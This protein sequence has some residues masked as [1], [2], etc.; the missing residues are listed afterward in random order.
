[1][2][3]PYEKGREYGIIRVTK[4]LSRLSLKGDR[5]LL[6]EILAKDL[7]RMRH[8]KNLTIKEL[9]EGIISE[10][11]YRRYLRSES[12]MTTDI[13]MRFMNRLGADMI[14]YTMDLN[15]R[16]QASYPEEYELA[17]LIK[18]NRYKEAARLYESHDFSRMYSENRY[19]FLP[20]LILYMKLNLKW[21]TK[22]EYM[23]QANEI[24]DYPNILQYKV[25]TRVD[26]EALLVHLF[27]VEEEDLERISNFLVDVIDNPD[28]RVISFEPDITR[29]DVLNVVPFA[30]LRKDHI[31][32]KD[33]QII[34]RMLEEF[35]TR[36]H[37][38]LEGFRIG[39]FIRSLISYHTV[40]NEEDK[41][42]MDVYHLFVYIFSHDKMSPYLEW[43]FTEHQ[44][45]YPGFLEFIE[46]EDNITTMAEM[47]WR[48]LV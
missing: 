1:M 11:M 2:N 7:E 36:C 9:T 10:R 34:K 23:K 19:R 31:S 28:I 29:F 35:G 39:L 12:K 20:I 44:S 30:L 26:I 17:Q 13:Y 27:V 21:I 43:L 14:Q 40:M 8:S 32:D 5:M 41:K 4:N 18:E 15:D 46:S 6:F 37:P 33:I 38:Y 48:D 47:N 16:I 25:L 3:L 42:V 22:K 45:Y 24:L